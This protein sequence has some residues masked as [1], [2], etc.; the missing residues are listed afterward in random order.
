MDTK[1]FLQS[2]RFWGLV[3]SIVGFAVTLVAQYFGH[4][5]TAYVDLAG[6]ILMAFGLPFTAY[7]ASVA[8]KPL[9]FTK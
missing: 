9:G 8:D 2:K 5:V 6:K 7:G 3:A 1:Y 4:D